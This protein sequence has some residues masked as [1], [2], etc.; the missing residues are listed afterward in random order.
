MTYLVL[1]E[2]CFIIDLIR[3]LNTHLEVTGAYF[4]DFGHTK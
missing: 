1:I 4:A 2:I 3:Q